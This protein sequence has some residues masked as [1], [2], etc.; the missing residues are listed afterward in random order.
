MLPWSNSS[1]TPL[2]QFLS[3]IFTFLSF[4]PHIS[5]A[6]DSEWIDYSPD[7]Y[8]TMTH[9]SLPENFIA[10]CGSVTSYGPACGQCFNLTL[11]N[12]FLSNPPFYPNVTNSV[13]IKVTDLCPL[14]LSGWCNATTHGPNAGGHYLNFDLAWPSL[15]IPNDF[16]PSD[17][18]LYG[19]TD[20]GVWNISY[21]SVSCTNWEG[22]NYAAALGSVANLGYSACCPDNPTVSRSLSYI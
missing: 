7:G 21:Q 1:A 13:V 8:A 16:F 5:W 2:S 9:Y 15:S 14:S 12:S 22:W 19:Y 4:L 18:S 10:A 20:F 11:L 17:E 6:S 3:F